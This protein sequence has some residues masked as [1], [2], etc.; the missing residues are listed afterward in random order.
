MLAASPA[1]I[2][3]SSQVAQVGR[4]AKLSQAVIDVRPNNEK[5]GAAACGDGG[6][7]RISE[8]L[9]KSS[10]CSSFLRRQESSALRS[11]VRRHW[12]TRH[13]SV[14]RALPASAGM[15]GKIRLSSRH[16]KALALMKQQPRK[17]EPKQR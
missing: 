6:V 11:A 1:T 16:G 17:Q 5:P 8:G 10:S 3:D 2:L 12:M 7:A 15:T 14:D 13:S 9:T 4:C